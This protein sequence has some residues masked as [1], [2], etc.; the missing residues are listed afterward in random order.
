MLD[1]IQIGKFGVLN[2]QK[3]ISTT[4]NN[5]NNV[6]TEGYTR[7]QTLTYTSSID[8]GVGNTDTRRIYS[9]YVQ[10]ELYAD[11]GNKSYYE[12]AKSGMS[13]VDSM[14]SD[15]EMSVSTAFTKYFNALSSS[16]A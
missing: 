5:I 3:L 13:A 9:Q 4:S 11:N 7:K 12:A 2:A 16:S 8:W 14:L 15:D 10:R 1:L 6:N